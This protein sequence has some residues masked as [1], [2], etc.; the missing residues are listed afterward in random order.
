MKITGILKQGQWY[1]GEKCAT[2][3]LDA[4]GIDEDKEELG[5][6][7]G[8]KDYEEDELPELDV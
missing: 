2:E 5:E 3:A 8:S 4:M 6:W 1:C 7:E